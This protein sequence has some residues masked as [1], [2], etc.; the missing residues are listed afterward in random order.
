MESY[1][2]FFAYHNW[3]LDDGLEDIELIFKSLYEKNRSLMLE[4]PHGRD[5]YT[6]IV[7]LAS[8]MSDS[9]IPQKLLQ[10]R[11]EEESFVDAD[12]DIELYRHLR[13]LPCFWH[14]H[15]FLE[16]ICVIQG[17]CKHYIA[18]REID[19][20]KG[21]ICIVAPDTRHAISVF[22]D[23]SIIL[24][25]LIRTSTFETAF[26]G[27]L[28]DDNVLSRFFNHTLYHSKTYPY[29][30]F[31][32]GYDQRLFNFVGYA[33]EEACEKH[34]YKKR[35]MN[36]I[37][38]GFFIMLLR[39]HGTN[40]IV[41]ELE[42]IDQDKNLV[43]ILKYMQEHYNTISLSDMAAFFNYSER[44][45]QRLIIS[46]TGMNFSA[47]ILKLKMTQAERLL[48]KSNMPIGEIAKNL[49]YT[50]P[51]NFRQTFKK[52]YNQTPTDYRRTLLS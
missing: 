48:S 36:S 50:D 10:E 8:K 37:I 1:M 20:Q 12:N 15:A 43:Y 5:T 35:M 45:I 44:Q 38:S 14:S 46:A 21:D 7:E 47:N 2:H 17:S 16:I 4:F 6:S 22:T 33:Y 9:S 30:F 39:N 49:G 18:E 34:Y 27:T 25:I 31:R 32:T 26:F 40:V 23:E 3:S 29:L 41:S 52:Y 51:R 28:I 13:Y 24:N 19:M 42:S 11:L